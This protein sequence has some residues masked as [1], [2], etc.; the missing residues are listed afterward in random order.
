V[1][2]AQPFLAWPGAWAELPWLAGAVSPAGVSLGAVSEL[3]ELAELD[4]ETVVAAGV[5]AV[6]GGAGSVGVAGGSDVVLG[7]G[8]AL[9][10]AGAGTPAGA[11]ESLPTAPLD[12]PADPGGSGV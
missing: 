1:K 11:L 2:A 3:T 12:S 10:S 9:V 6:L 4:V 8:D 5:A 7:A